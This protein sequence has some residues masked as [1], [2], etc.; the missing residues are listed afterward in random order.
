MKGNQN[1]PLLFFAILGEAALRTMPPVEQFDVISKWMSDPSPKASM[2]S[3]LQDRKTFDGLN[4][5]ALRVE[6][7]VNTLA[8][9]PNMRSHNC[10]ALNFQWPSEINLPFLSLSLDSEK[11]VKMMQIRTSKP[12]GCVIVLVGGKYLQRIDDIV[13]L[14]DH[15]TTQLAI[16]ILTFFGRV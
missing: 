16:K 6:E 12:N 15:I 8:Y 9:S 7:R 14:V 5:E 2:K 11:S 13:R 1:V 3:T 10:F 4:L